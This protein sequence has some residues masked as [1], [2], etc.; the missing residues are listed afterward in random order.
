MP[1]EDVSNLLGRVVQST[2]LSP[3]HHSAPRSKEDKPA[4]NPADIIPDILPAL[5]TL[6]QFADHKVTT[7]PGSPSYAGPLFKAE[8]H[9][10]EEQ[11]LTL[12]CDKLEA[13]VLKDTG[14][15]VEML[16]ANGHYAS[17]VRGILTY[18]WPE[19]GYLVTGFL[20][21]TNSR[22][23]TDSMTDHRV[24]GVVSS[25][26]TQD[27]ESDSSEKRVI[28]LLYSCVKPF[29][30]DFPVPQYACS[31]TAAQRGLE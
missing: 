28:A 5:A 8:L 12:I 13:Y 20:I 10:Y 23:T 4:H 1:A 11:H 26:N 16:L 21:A 14:Q 24:G 22:W 17:D 2:T 7:V 3:L 9:S 30:N 18:L 31:G 19:P 15:K 29:Y 25:L 27:S 6:A